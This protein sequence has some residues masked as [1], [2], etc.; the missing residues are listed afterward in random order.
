MKRF[1]SIIGLE[2]RT[3]FRDEGVL[4]VLVGALLL[5]SALYGLIY[6]PEVVR[7]M[8]VAVVDMDSSPASQELTRALDATPAA[9]V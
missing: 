5:Y 7:D 6:E 8:P 4:L 2:F 9:H 1:F 3:I